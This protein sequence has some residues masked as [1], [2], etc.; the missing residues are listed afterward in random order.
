MLKYSSPQLVTSS[1]G[2]CGEELS[3]LYGLAIRNLTML[4]W[5]YR[6]YKLCFFSLFLLLL[7]PSPPS[8]PSSSLLIL[9]L[10][11]LGIHK[12]CGVDLRGL[13]SKCNQG[14]CCKTLK[15]SIKILWKNQI[16]S[17]YAFPMCIYKHLVLLYLH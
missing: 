14:S 8:H 13:A 7:S 9:S 12:D 1:G 4:Q 16:M 5:E 17:I 6:Q 15:W 3:F 11:L 10:L 2:I